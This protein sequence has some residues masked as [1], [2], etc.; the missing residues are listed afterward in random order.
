MTGKTH[1]STRTLGY[2]YD[3]DGDLITFSGTL[4]DGTSRTYA[5]GI[6]YNA[7]GQMIREQFGTTKALYHRRHYNSRGQLFDVRLGTD[8]SS[9]NDGADPAAWTGKSWN[10]GALRLYYSSNQTDYSWPFTTGNAPQHNNGNLYRIDHFVPTALDGGDN[11]TAWGLGVDY[12][13]Y[14]SLNRVTGVTEQTYDSA[15]GFNPATFSQQ[16]SYDRFG[17]RL[18]SSSNVPN[19][20][21][22][23]FKIHGPTNRLIAPTDVDGSNASDKMRYDAAGN[24]IKD[25]HTQT[26]T[27]GTRVYDAENRMTGADGTNGLANGYVYNADGKRTRRSI[28]SGGAVWW[29]VYGIGGELVAEYRV[30]GGVPTLKKEYGYRN[31]E[32]LVVWDGDETGDKRWQWRVT[33][34]LGTARM[35]VD[36]SG[37]FGAMKRRDYLPFGEEILAGVGH[38]TIGNGYPGMLAANPRQHFTGKERDKEISLDYFEA[39]Y[40]SSIQGRFTSPDEFQGGPHEVLVMGSGHPQ[41]QALPYANILEPQSLNKYPYCLNNPLRYIDPDGHAPFGDGIWERLGQAID[42]LKKSLGEMFM[43]EKNPEQVDEETRRA[44]QRMAAVGLGGL[45]DSDR[46]RVDHLQKVGQGMEV[47]NN[48]LALVDPTG[49][50]SVVQAAARGDNTGVVIAIGGMVF[51]GGKSNITLR[52]AKTLMGGWARDPVQNTISASIKYHFKTHGAELG[53]KDVWQYLRQ[54]ASFSTKGA[55]RVALEDGKTRY[56]KNGKYIIKDADDKIISYGLER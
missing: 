24:Q 16:F 15:G 51:G 18:V 43:R 2:Q 31:G 40:F 29:H 11:I 46:V 38:R 52:E 9:V 26:G 13:G 10:Y 30:I 17:N 56:I 34:Q 20:P 4:G 36:L 41:K 12:Y 7:Q 25:T 47:V 3:A 39:R 19:A 14:D 27:T 55:R 50:V 5:S 32:L 37:T 44:E 21:N 28:D 53:A 22:P 6:E 45:G 48:I 35:L 42:D 49:S 1:P 54:A 8:S 33:D 23:G